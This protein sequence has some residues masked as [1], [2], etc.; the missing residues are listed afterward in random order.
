M[1][2]T[3]PLSKNKCRI[4]STRVILNRSV[5]PM[6]QSAEITNNPNGYAEEILQL[7]INRS[8]CTCSKC[9]LNL[10][11]NF[12]SVLL[13]SNF[14]GETWL[15]GKIV[16]LNTEMQNFHRSI[17]LKQFQ[18]NVSKK[19]KTF[20]SWENSYASTKKFKLHFAF[21]T[22]LSQICTF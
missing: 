16:H 5:L 14:T 13:R 1:I 21:R 12:P 8:C 15:W 3:L 18:Q 11:V 7:L 10:P 6:S 4:A 22:S 2:W 20:T 19:T 9:Y 17:H